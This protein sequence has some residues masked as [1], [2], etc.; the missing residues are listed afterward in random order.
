MQTLSVPELTADVGLSARPDVLLIAASASVEALGPMRSIVAMK[1]AANVVLA[2][3]T[4]IHPSAEIVARRLHLGGASAD[5]A[6]KVERADVQFDAEVRVPLEERLELW[7]RAERA[8]RVCE[9][10]AR[11]AIELSKRKPAVKLGWREPLPRVLNV[12]PARERLI[13]SY[14]TRI[15]RLLD[16]VGG[17][18]LSL[19]WDAPLEVS[20]YAVSL[21]EVRLTLGA[22]G[23]A[24]R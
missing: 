17:G 4:E 21:D 9:A 14:N 24:R 13:E 15:R 5:K 12:E 3:L 22:G 1:E 2:H 16:G 23:A 10:L 8:A 7:S 6:A 19:P 20:Q 18:A 11:A